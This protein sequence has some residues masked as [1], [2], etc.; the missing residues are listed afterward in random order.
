[1]CIVYAVV[2]LS[3]VCNFGYKYILGFLMVKDY[4]II[5]C[6]TSTTF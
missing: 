6:T 5:L 1:M 4:L 3:S 2:F